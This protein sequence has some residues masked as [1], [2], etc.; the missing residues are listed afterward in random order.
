MVAKSIPGSVENVNEVIVSYLLW[1][2]LANSMF[3]DR[4]FVRIY[5]NCLALFLM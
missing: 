4:M 1:Q 2:E 5:S 3:R